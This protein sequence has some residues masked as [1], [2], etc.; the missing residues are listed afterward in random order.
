MKTVSIKTRN[1]SDSAKRE[2]G[3]GHQKDF[4]GGTASRGQKA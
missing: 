2:F 1:R 3:D 4:D